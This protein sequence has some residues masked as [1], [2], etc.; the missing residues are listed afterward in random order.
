VIT[1]ESAYWAQ[2]LFAEP[3]T[4]ESRDLEKPLSAGVEYLGFRDAGDG[5]DGGPE[6]VCMSTQG[7]PGC[8]T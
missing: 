7:K 1:K 5:G 6:W 4:E 3:S 8:V 2:G